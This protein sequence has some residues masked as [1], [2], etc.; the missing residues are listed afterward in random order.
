M[1]TVSPSGS[2]AGPEQVRIRFSQ[3]MVALGDP[4]APAPASVS[5]GQ[6]TGRWVD[7]REWAFD[8]SEALA[9]GLRCRVQLADGL[10]TLAG[11][12]L[13][14]QRSFGFDTG[15]PTLLHSAPASDS[16][17]VAEDQV[18]A[19]ALNAQPTAQSVAANARCIIEGVGEQV[20]FDPLSEADSR[21]LVANAAR[22]YELRSFLERAGWL[23]PRYP[24][25]GGEPGP[26]RKL[27]LLFGQCRRT[28]PPKARVVVQWGAGIASASGLAT[29]KPV[30][31]SVQ[32]RA[33]F[34]ARFSCSR[35]SPAAACSPV[36]PMRVEFGEQVPFEAAM[37]A[38]LIALDGTAI[39]P[40]KP[41]RREPLLSAI[42]FKGPFPEKMSYRVTL[43]PGLRDVTGRALANAARFPLTVRT[44]E[45]PPLVKF[46]GTFGIIEAEEG[47]VLPV[48]MRNVEPAVGGR[49][50]A[51]AG[52]ALRLGQSDGEIADW[53]RRLDRAEEHTHIDE[54]I[55]G[56]KDEDGEPATRR[57][58]T[59]RST[60]LI[61]AAAPT[62]ALSVPKP[63]GAQ[64]FEVVGIPLKS[65]GFYV[66]ELASPRL[67][68]A[69]LGPGR[70]RYVATGA[71]VTNLSVH[72]AW[73]VGSSLAWVTRL[74]DAQPVV[75]ALVRVTDSCTGRLIAE[76]RTGP[77]G[78][79]QVQGLPEPDGYGSCEGS[80][81]PLMVSARAGDD[82]SFTLTSWNRGIQPG[83]FHLDQGYGARDP[84]QTHTVFDRTL[85]RAGET[86]H[87]KLLVRA[88][89]DKGF[90]LPPGGDATL[91][92]AHE[93][94]DAK[95][96]LPVKLGAQGAALAE[97]TAPKE[98][99]LGTYRVT[100][101]GRPAGEFQVEEFRLPTMRAE[102]RGP[103]KPLVAP[104]VA[105]LDLTLAY[106]SG[107]AASGAAVTVRSRVE[108]RSID[109]PDYPGFS[110]SAD[111][112][113]EGVRPASMDGDDGD[114]A[115]A[116]QLR[117]NVTPV[118]LD[119]DGRAQVDAPV[120]AAVEQ[121]SALVAE[122]DYEGANGERRTARTRVPLEP[123]GLRVG[124][125]TDG[126]LMKADDVRLKLAVLDLAGRPL[127]GQHVDV[128]LY[129]RETYSY[130]KRL[131]G[132]FYAFDNTV[133]TKRLKAD[134]S[135]TS[136]A[137]GYA[138]CRIDAGVSGEV[139]ALATV[140]D[141]D[142]HA[143]RAST[144]LY[145][146]GGDDWWFGGD[147]GDRM[148]VLPERPEYATG[149]TARLQVR[150]P[151]RHATA[152]VTISRDG[153]M[154]SFVTELDGR[155]PVIDVAMK[156][157]WSPNI[158]VSV[159]AV[160]GRVSGWRLWLANLAR[161]WGL[162]DWLAPREAHAP[163]AL[164][165]LAKPAYRLGI[166]KIRVG[167][168]E[169]RLAVKV[170]PAAQRYAVR[171][172]ADVGIEVAP[173]R[174]AALPTGAEIAVAAV[175]EALLDLKP[176]ESWDVLTPLMAQQPTYV[177]FSTAQ[178]QVVG[179]RHYGRK[180]VAAGGGGGTG[181]TPPRADFK[182]LLLWAGSVPLDANG[183]ASIR[184]PLNDSL[185]SFRV[186]AVATAGAGLFGT[187]AATIATTQDLI[188]LS[189]LPPLVRTGDVYDAPVTIRNTTG[190]ELK[191]R[192]TA[193]AGTA[194]LPPQNVLLNPREN[195]TLSWRVAAPGDEGEVRWS[196]AA[197]AGAA[198]DRLEVA[199]T[200]R[201]A[202]PV[203]TLAA[204]FVQVNGQTSVPVAPP[205]DALPG[206]GGVQ[207]A[208]S[209]SIGGD[210]AGA[211]DF[212]RRYP[213]D[214][215]EQDASRA[216]VLSDRAA[217]DRLMLKLPRY[218]DGTGLV[219]FFPADWV[220][221]DDSLT[222]YIL[223]LSAGSGWPI[224]DDPR[225]KMVAALKRVIGGGGSSHEDV[226]V[227]EKGR[228]IVGRA[229]LA[230]DLALRRVA[231]LAALA[232]AGEASAAM[233]DTVAA[234][235]NAWPTSTVAQWLA[236]LN[237]LEPGGA[238]AAAASAVLRAR[239]DSQGSALV[240]A[241]RDQL[242][243]L[244]GSGDG[245]AARVLLAAVPRRE[246]AA[247]VPRVARGLIVRTR[248]GGW[249]T[250]VANALATIAL[251]RFGERF[252]RGPVGGRT[253]VALGGSAP[254]AVLW[255]DPRPVA[256]PWGN[257]A[258]PL[259]L[260]HEGTGAPWAVV[261]AR[262]AVPLKAP[263]QSGFA[264]RRTVTAVSRKT[265]GVWTR[266]DV[267]RVRV[268]VDTRA[269]A[270]WTVIDDPVPAGATILGGGLGGRSEILDSEGA[271]R[272]DGPQPAY[273]ERKQGATRAYFDWVPRGRIVHEYTL[274]LGTAGRFALPP[275][276]V[277]AMY[278]PG[279]IALIP[280][281]AI[282]VR[283]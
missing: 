177:F 157:G 147:N 193:R 163:T 123:A 174:G 72:F 98:A 213:Y 47:G 146:A 164:I 122:M 132:G 121:P 22:N 103:G 160:R 99:A 104:K 263:V 65:P 282:E 195:R 260:K 51:V 179:K 236:A 105:P 33:P 44:D 182:P 21:A 141:R 46:A 259:V 142:G 207:V 35:V 151:F 58:E 262:G 158:Y 93:A 255:P 202:V 2:V 198:A 229:N 97:W 246:W 37:Q 251:K 73:G 231:A 32:V 274:R 49:V 9:G 216:V 128:A 78:R 69:L 116:E 64:A 31:I 150:M 8:F 273:V 28:L 12:A 161:E 165:D 264:V 226:L 281:A 167:W 188:L 88:R 94:T 82:M 244:L 134:C 109:L 243:W 62:R 139:I 27:P 168:D 175:D 76:G 221:G 170:R 225:G 40:V 74:S 30:A 256:L 267:M 127:G 199:Q 6:G 106:F 156:P 129:S 101:D 234:D 75:G 52:R 26:R 77:G 118:A 183:R 149:E 169:H 70:T 228:G 18:F 275:T 83:D 133:E 240:L 113:V 200:V 269:D 266:G 80:S 166:A 248:R 192:L 189:G 114:G 154:D 84:V 187:G 1:E 218:L 115:P 66:V 79:L 67:G 237:R 108:T 257:G 204:T 68:S 180:A 10:K 176:N 138:T 220:R 249:D 23:E 91:I 194:L 238:R 124:I 56:M 233:L 3:P 50:Q 148:D 172:M 11:T 181:G 20:P 7:T 19:L 102:V 261:S 232:E 241:R 136:D 217:W 100:L 131:I 209:A 271:S 60:P 107:G 184:V 230:G 111:R 36:E 242:W 130:R 247:D 185:S 219:R 280:N 120:A 223:T 279:T 144:Q 71:L 54:P 205:A 110:W 145:L 4:R 41:E 89:S 143:A 119:A 208:L 137:R 39:E 24:Q 152:L 85:I 38:R 29:G 171:Q 117:A 63:G 140:K 270:N 222:A 159:M 253:L 13:E 87:M 25:D 55:A 112:I 43:A 227:V 81:H 239:L 14:G 135:A 235:P 190:R 203:Q 268:E 90:A 15:G 197:Q 212:M 214:C 196:F 206:K 153:V 178:S 210:L 61:P 162:P 42:E 224:P 92:I 59:T 250:T 254:A 201:A 186:V 155:E 211:K 125:R 191:V 45:A 95:W 53:V 57:I 17:R 48:T 252:E 96:T 272:P 258:E 276:R 265:D 16:G 215:F 34:V 126:W 173:P 278:V 277:E 5:C 245:T 86:I 283:P